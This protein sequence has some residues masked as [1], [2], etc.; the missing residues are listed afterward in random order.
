MRR[1]GQIHFLGK[2]PLPAARAAE[3]NLAL[4]SEEQKER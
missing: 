1:F 3:W 2:T 4:L